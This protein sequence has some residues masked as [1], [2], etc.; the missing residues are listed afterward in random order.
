MK[1]IKTTVVNKRYQEYNIYIGR[2][3]K[4]GNP[5]RIGEDG[6][7]EEVIMK[8]KEWI[9][10]QPSLLRDLHELKG[11]RLGCYCRPWHHCHGDVLVELIEGKDGS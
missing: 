4:W 6:D 8:Y 9:L 3:S 2:G 11:K 7:R 10:E 1:E 5:F